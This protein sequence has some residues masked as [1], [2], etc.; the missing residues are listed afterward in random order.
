MK[1]LPAME[2]GAGERSGA[3]CER[4]SGGRE[5]E[6]EAEREREREG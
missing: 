2:V 3:D 4:V 1:G 5:M 6:T